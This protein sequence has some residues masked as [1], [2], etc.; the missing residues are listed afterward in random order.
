MRG[1]ISTAQE[2][3]WSEAGV[4]THGRKVPA[5]GPGVVSE[6]RQGASQHKILS[7][8]QLLPTCPVAVMLRRQS[9]PLAREDLVG[10][11]PGRPTPPSTAQGGPG[12]GWGSLALP[13]AVL[14]KSLKAL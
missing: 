10:Q 14:A 5:S 12:R 4:L 3:L 13:P 8:I 2:A 9:A 1:L 11:P 6:R 7:I